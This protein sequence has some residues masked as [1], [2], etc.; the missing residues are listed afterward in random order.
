MLTTAAA[1]VLAV[2]KSFAGGRRKHATHGALYFLATNKR[3]A[4][5]V[6]Q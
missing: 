5:A 6:L 4:L 1:H 3:T 2:P